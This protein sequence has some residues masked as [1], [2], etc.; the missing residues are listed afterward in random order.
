MEELVAAVDAMSREALGE[1]LRL[2]LSSATAMSTLRSTEA[3]GPLR[4]EILYEL[5]I[6]LACLP[7]F[8]MPLFGHGWCGIEVGMAAASATVW[9]GGPCHLVRP[10]VQFTCCK[11][12]TIAPTAHTLFQRL[13]CFY[14]YLPNP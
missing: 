3:L 10:Q 14:A 4:Y 1:A 9:C 8:D 6:S 11:L 12:H 5:A 2:V 7:G 13:T